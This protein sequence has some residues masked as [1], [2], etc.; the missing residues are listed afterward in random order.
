MQSEVKPAL[1]SFCDSLPNGER[2]NCYSLINF[3]QGMEILTEIIVCSLNHTHFL[4]YDKV[5]TLIWNCL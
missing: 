2:D 5:I 4:F 3:D 1:E